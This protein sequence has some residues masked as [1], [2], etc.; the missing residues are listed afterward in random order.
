MNLHGSHVVEGARDPGLA[1]LRRRSWTALALTVPLFAIEG[2]APGGILPGSL[3]LSTPPWLQLLLATPV[4]L[5][6]GWPL[7]QRLWRSLARGTPDRFTLLGL[8]VLV[9][10]AFGALATL[11]PQVVPAALRHG[12]HPALYL[13]SAA[14]IVTLFLFGQLLE[15][16][17]W[18]SAGE[19][20]HALPEATLQH[21]L[22]SRAPV[23]EF[24]D[25]VSAW[26][27]PAVIA[28]AVLAALGWWAFGPEPRL[29]H[30]LAVAVCTLVIACPGSLRLAT[31]LSM[32]V[33]M[34]RAARA[35]VLFRDA[36]ALERLKD[37]DT[38]VF[39]RTGT[40]TV[41]RPEVV[42]VIP[43]DGVAESELLRL[44]A[45]LEQSS[46]HPIA[47]AVV[48]TALARGLR[49]GRSHSLR[50][51]AG[52]GA[53]GVVQLR[54][55][56]V[57]NAALMDEAG[58]DAGSLE[59]EARRLRALGQ[60]VVFVGLDG[61]PVGLLGLA[62]PLRP[63]AWE[64]VRHLEAEGMRVLVLSCDHE[65]SVR[66]VAAEL[67]IEEVAAG[68]L[69]DAKAT[70]IR[71]LRS[72]GHLVAMVGSGSADAPAL[73]A[74]DVGIAM[75]GTTDDAQQASGVMLVGGDLHGLLRAIR[76]SEATLR[77]VGQNLLFAFGY[78]ALAVPLA[79][80]ALYPFAGLLLSPAVAATATSLASACVIGNALRLRSVRA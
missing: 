42:S 1:G 9:T 2:A 69:P 59:P 45:S 12:A 66:T 68:V 77:N 62:D 51:V 43:V 72:A 25:R 5:W 78:N 23:Q 76:V 44:A 48:A 13:G 30:A 73:A 33:A 31:P 57:G 50:G 40:L 11:P 6:C 55:V 10:Y 35:G 8:G 22:R 34:G 3:G 49:L 52:K 80:G 74:A 19:A 75:G 16:R 53:I 41:G 17:A 14:L 24:A 60:T 71:E 39:E 28:I 27:V 46:A 20:L 4:V 32:T 64:V 7:L 56:A 63:E 18:H 65:D 70:R 79:V 54:N 38:V 67:G 37:V 47:A 36:E 58:I 29:A 15:R 26:F 61:A 21:A